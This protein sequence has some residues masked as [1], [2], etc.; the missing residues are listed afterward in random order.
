MGFSTIA[1][2]AILG[3]TCIMIITIFSGGILPTITN[4][5]EAFKNMEDRAVE[6]VNTNINITSVTNTSGI[7]YDF[8]IT[9][10]NTGQIT[11]KILD[12]TI[13]VNGIKEQFNCSD[14]YLFPERETI[15]TLNL[16][17]SGL[18]RIKVVT[19]NGIFD[20]EEYIV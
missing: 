11:L 16:T 20:Y 3:G 7:Y 9:V 13:I 6:R 5:H 4:Y 14:S 15:F 17:G 2:T 12:F 19:E 8:N 18:K 10:N 1:A